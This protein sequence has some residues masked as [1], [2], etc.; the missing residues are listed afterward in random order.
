MNMKRL[1]C[2]RTFK[3]KVA[4]LASE[5]LPKGERESM[6]DH[7]KHC[8]GC[9]QYHDE[10]AM[11][12]GGMKAWASKEQPEVSPAFRARWMRSIQDLDNSPHGL[13]S[14]LIRWCREWLWPSPVAWGALAL[15]W[16]CLQLLNSSV[17]PAVGRHMAK[18]AS[19]ERDITLAQRQRELASLLE[20]LAPHKQQAPILNPGPRSERPSKTVFL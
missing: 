4:L 19:I 8:A 18:D 3:E 13:V 14:A 1:T 17:A 16:I 2:C 10:I 20:T 12:T 5:S 7:L 9:R 15:V 11:V 6:L